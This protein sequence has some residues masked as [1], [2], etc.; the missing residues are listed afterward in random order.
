MRYLVGRRK[1]GNRRLL[2]EVICKL[3]WSPDGKQIALWLLTSNEILVAGI[4]KIKL[5]S[6][7]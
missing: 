5:S 6:P 4:E 7:F 3:R 1:T 2:A